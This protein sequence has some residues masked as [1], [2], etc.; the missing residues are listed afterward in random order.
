MFRCVQHIKNRNICTHNHFVYYND[1]LD[2][3][4]KQINIHIAEAINSPNYNELCETILKSIY[5]QAHT[6]K[7]S[8]LQ[9]ELQIINKTIRDSYKTL[10]PN[11]SIDD[12]DSIYNSQKRLMQKISDTIDDCNSCDTDLEALKKALPQ[13]LC[14]YSIDHSI[15]NLFVSKI[16][17]GHLE[18]DSTHSQQKISIYFRF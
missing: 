16:L 13:Y 8:K 3:V 6:I 11:S 15:I 9:K 2:E 18:R 1:L 14:T 5:A 10:R 17:I 4:Q 7:R 12:L